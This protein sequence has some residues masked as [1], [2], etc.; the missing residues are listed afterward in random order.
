ML[1]ALQ[2]EF[3]LPTSSYATMLIRELTKASTAFH[4]QPIKDGTKKTTPAAEGIG[5]K[6]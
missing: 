2:L 4:H 3:T 6:F 1:L 5:A